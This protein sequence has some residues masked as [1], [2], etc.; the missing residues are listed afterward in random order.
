MDLEESFDE[1]SNLDPPLQHYL[2]QAAL[3]EAFVLLERL[4]E[5]LR[6]QQPPQSPRPPTPPPELDQ[7]MLESQL[8]DFDAP[9][10]FFPPQPLPPVDWALIAYGLVMLAEAKYQR[11]QQQLIFVSL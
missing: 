4:D 3:R 1:L 8:A 11:Q 7:G 5:P 10:Q 9:Q 2:R 6:Q